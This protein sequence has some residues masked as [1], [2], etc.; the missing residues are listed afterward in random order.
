M[1]RIKAVVRSL[2]VYWLLSSRFS[3]VFE[4]IQL[5]AKTVALP[6]PASWAPCKHHSKFFH[7]FQVQDSV[8]AFQS[9]AMGGV[10]RKQ[11]FPPSLSLGKRKL[12][13][14]SRVRRVSRL[15]PDSPFLREAGG[16]SS[17]RSQGQREV[18]WPFEVVPSASAARRR[19]GVAGLIKSQQLINSLTR[20]ALARRPKTKAWA[21]DSG[22]NCYKTAGAGKEVRRVGEPRHRV[23]S[24]RLTAGRAEQDLALKW[25]LLCR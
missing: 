11:I 3:P 22:W 13:L 19:C 1:R 16:G 14:G 4:V 6:L 9:P 8:D 24:L 21:R 2:P 5:I 20:G 12:C 17:P 18:S 25:Q 15:S 7:S 10:A 23:S